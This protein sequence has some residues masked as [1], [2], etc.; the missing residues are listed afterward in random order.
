[1]RPVD[2]SPAPAAGRAEAARAALA[3]CARA[4]ALARE[5]DVEVTS[6]VDDQRFFA[7]LAAHEVLLQDLAEQ[8]VVLRRE[9]PAADSAILAATERMVDD[10]D[11]LVGDVCAAVETTHHLTVELA[12]KV[13]RRAEALRAE[14]ETVQHASMTGSAYGAPGGAR[15]VDLRR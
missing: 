4:D 9:R 10:A 6:T 11:A 5:M 1:M 13:G 15:L 12:V 3:L 7:L 2:T 8:L 14:L